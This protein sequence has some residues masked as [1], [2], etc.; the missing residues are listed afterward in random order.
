M[1]SKFFF[2]LSSIK[3]QYKYDSGN[4]TTVTTEQAPGLVDISFSALNLQKN[5]SIEP[6][7]HPNANK[8]GYCVD[9]N[10]LVSIRT[11]V[12][13][14]LFTITKGEVFFIPKG[15]IHHIVNT[16]DSETSI[17]FALNNT[18][19]EQMIL[20][21]AM[22][23]LSDDVF[24]ETF[25]I[26]PELLNGLK[27]ARKQDL[28]HFLPSKKTVPNFISSRYKFNLIDSADL[29]LTKGG[30]VQA[31]TKTNLPVLDGLGILGF[32]LNPKSAVEPHWHTNAGELVF[33]LKGKTEITVLAPDGKVSV[34]EVNAGEGAFAAASHF[35]NIQNS[36]D[37]IVQV[38]AFFTNADPDYIGLGEVIGAYSN[39]VL[40]SIFNVAPT[41]FDPLVKPTGPLVIVPVK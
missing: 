37:E 34:M 19:P 29:I 5:G 30:F 8:V 7:W 15:Y 12:S 13:V 4:I 16:G 28:I 3:P 32:G 14:E 22:L 36:G 31:A 20:T 1:A 6:M 38:M 33:I 39:E 10:A 26:P 21:N 23:S 18:K 25:N 2:S 9:G 41:Y 11:P 40:A 17:I 24:K 35:H 27:K